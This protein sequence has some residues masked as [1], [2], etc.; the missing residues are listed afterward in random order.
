MTINSGP[1]SYNGSSQPAVVSAV[2]IDGVTPVAGSVTYITYNGSTSVPKVLPEPILVFA[3][4]NCRRPGLLCR[5]RHRYV[6]H[7]QSDSVIQQ[8]VIA[9]GQR[10]YVYHHDLGP[11]RR[12]FD[13]SR[14]GR[15]GRHAQRR[16][17][18][19]ATVSGGGSFSTSF[20]ITGLATGSYPVTYQYSVDATHFNEA[21]NDS[22][23]G[24]LTVQAVPAIQTSPVSQTV[25]SG[26]TVTFSASASG[27]PVPTVQWQSSTNG[28]NYTNIAGA[29]SPTYTISAA[30]VSQN[31]YRYRAV[32]TNRVG[33]A[34][35]AAA[36]LTVQAAP[37]G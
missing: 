19:P 3:E 36:T 18:Q 16:H 21:G 35:T 32:F 17:L 29:T 27:Y 10:R 4:W 7:Q 28:N 12:G 26:T 24:T 1:L 30:T 22:A 25:L 8:P 6:R 37:A 23:V 9:G 14:R 34:T 15:R 33:S 5:H 11:H 13:G 2:G 31:G 20:N